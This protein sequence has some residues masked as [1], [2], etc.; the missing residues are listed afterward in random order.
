MNFLIKKKTILASLAL[1][2]VATIALFVWNHQ[3]KTSENDEYDGPDQAAQFEFE[4][5]KDPKTGEV[6]TFRLLEA[7]EQTELSKQA[8]AATALS[9]TERGPYS[10]VAGPVNGN[11]RANNDITGG[12]TRAVWVDLR[13][14][15]SK[16]V[17]VA[18][19]AGGIWKTTDITLSNPN[20]T[21]LND[22]WTNLA[23]TGICQSPA[24]TTTFYCCTGE[25]FYNGGAVQGVGV[26]KSTDGGVTWANLASSTGFTY[27]TK[28]LCD[29]S[30]NVY[31]GT[32]SGLQRSTDGGTTWTNITPTGLNSNIADFEISSTGRLHV[33]CGLS[34][35]A[36]GG[37]RFTSAP[38]TVTSSTWT[39][40]TTPFTFPSGSNTR[41]ELACS[42]NTLYAAPSDN[43]AY[44]RQ[45]H[46]STDGGVTW[47]TTALT[48]TNISDLNG[49]N[50]NSQAWYCIGLGIDPSNS[51]NV[52]VGNLRLIS[53]TDGGATW[54]KISEWV[55]TSGQYVHADIQNITWA[56]NGNK[57]LI[58]CDG[59]IHYSS[60]KGATFRDRNTNYRVKQF[61]SC[62]IH[63]SSTNYFLAGAQD[64]GT[65]Q[66][67]GVGL[68]TS[69]EV[70]GGDGMF[71]AI[72]QNQPTYQFGSYVYNTYRRSSN[73]GSNWD[74]FDIDVSSTNGLFVN[75][76]DYDN[77]NNK[78]Y[79]TWSNNNYLRWD[80][81]QTVLS[82]GTPATAVVNVTAFNS[83]K[84]STIFVS[85][86]TSHQVYFGTTGGRIIKAAAANTA[87]PTFTNLTSASMPASGYVSCINVGTTENQLITCFSNYGISNIWT[88]SDGGTTWTAIDGNLPDMP[89]RWVMYFPGDNTRAFAATETGVWETTLING[90]ST[91][92]TANSTFPN[93]RTDMLKFRSSDR[94]IV[95]ATY[96]RGL[97]TATVNAPF[98]VELSAF[99]AVEK[100][101]HAVLTWTTASER[102]NVGFD[103]EKSSDGQRFE[104]IGFQKGANNSNTTQYYTFTDAAIL[105]NAVQYYRL[106]QIDAD[107]K[108]TYSPIISL[109][110][111]GK[112]PLE[113]LSVNNPFDASLQVHFNLPPENTIHWQLFDL[114]GRLQYTQTS[115]TPS[116]AVP[117]FLQS[118]VYVLRIQIGAQ[119]FTRKVWKW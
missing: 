31:L 109:S 93:V 92:W 78:I 99:K 25:A 62:A 111:Q 32:R 49:T 4:R 50:T 42:G 79:A 36:S 52:I 84:A 96:G 12:R 43:N 3:D 103:I 88:S 24:S 86:Y 104:K 6:P 26:F 20:W 85:P 68:T 56:D 115:E 101:N 34:N 59:G 95:A 98:P 75:P 45:I 94:T 46:K 106:R 10:D 87:T 47:T 33:S 18:G 8:K 72:D 76:W 11:T 21:L 57:L 119:I 117:N 102:Q 58:G 40:A 37:Y 69:V 22:K 114:A 74:Y 97:W 27:C 7:I 108:S 39:S 60:D 28:I 90:S 14:N 41:C 38:S 83:T 81:P 63:P 64:N 67:N 91:V 65:H 55:G 61:Y 82:G 23:V 48:A 51:N 2:V 112:M 29:A 118:G 30:G 9:W 66:F 15:T 89:V 54:T 44:I 5:T 16:T 110:G 107:G 113:L 17:W 71:V 100:N 73:S 80:D 105:T 1:W 77:A 70:F 13:D 53:S 116:I 35:T 19:V